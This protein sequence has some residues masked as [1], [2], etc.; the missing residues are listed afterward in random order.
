MT[1]ICAWGVWYL[2]VRVLNCTQYFVSECP[3]TTCPTV[4]EEVCATNGVTYKN[5]C[6]LNKVKCKDNT[7]E[8]AYEGECT[9]NARNY[10]N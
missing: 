3:I 10:I 5:L 4:V 6:E 9:G 7:I 8:M 2:L 1:R